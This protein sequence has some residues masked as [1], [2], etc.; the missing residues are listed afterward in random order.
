MY[1]VFSW[2]K[3]IAVLGLLVFAG[4]G[5]AGGGRQ[6]DRGFRT[7]AGTAHLFG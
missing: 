2:K 5:I 3:A 7:P 1:G 6:G 4:F